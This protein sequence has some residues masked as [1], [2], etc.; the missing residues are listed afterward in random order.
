MK[1][2]GNML[3]HQELE[4]TL[5]LGKV[6]G[7]PEGEEL[8]GGE[9]AG[10]K[11]DWAREGSRDGCQPRC[12]ILCLLVLTKWCRYEETL[13]GFWAFTLHNGG[14]EASVAAPTS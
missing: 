11:E 10:R 9:Q 3:Y 12:P 14:N 4:V 1:V 7:G 6:G 2:P 13:W 5:G 8:G